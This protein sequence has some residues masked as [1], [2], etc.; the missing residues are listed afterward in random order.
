MIL[1]QIANLFNIIPTTSCHSASSPCTTDGASQGREEHAK[2]ALGTKKGL[3]AQS[4]CTTMYEELL[5][6]VTFVMQSSCNRETVSLGCENT[7]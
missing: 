2:I 5:L 1:F 7:V 6:V 4:R 3:S